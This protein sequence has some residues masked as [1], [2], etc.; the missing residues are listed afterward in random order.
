MNEV[1]VIGQI[2]LL[3]KLQGIDMQIYGLK[4]EAEEKP[5]ESRGLKESLEGKKTGV[6]E[7][8]TRLKALQLKHKEKEMLLS[9]KE[10]EIK[11]L[12]GQLYQIKTN[13]EYS[14]MIGEIG[15]RK[16]DNSILEEEII[17][18]IDC[19]D[20]AKSEVEQ[21]KSKFAEE[22]VRIE[23]KIKEVEK[24]L[25]A[26]LSGI[27]ELDKKRMEITPLIEGKLLAEYERVLS[28]RNGQALAAVVSGNCGGCHMHLPPQ[29]VNEIKIGQSIIRCENC[30][31]ILYINN[32]EKKQ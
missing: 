16:A 29:V 13:K 15:S 22:S 24:S 3:V 7:S 4:S 18:L 32:D 17:N 21:E 1:D 28:A 12:E 30:Q 26:I 25:N 20:R 27:E 19:I 8:E 14:A 31:R 10:A 23:N 2:S 6:K 9:S 5:I 11:K